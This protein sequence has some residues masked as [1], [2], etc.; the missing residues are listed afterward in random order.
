MLRARDT[1]THWHTI[2]STHESGLQVPAPAVVEEA[3]NDSSR[4]V[5]DQDSQKGYLH[6]WYDK[7]HKFLQGKSKDIKK[8]KNCDVVPKYLKSNVYLF[9]YLIFKGI[10]LVWTKYIPIK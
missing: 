9:K 8:R 2:R 3:N 1:V 10:C 6:V 7:F 4:K 5:T